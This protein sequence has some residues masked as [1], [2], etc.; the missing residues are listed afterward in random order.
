MI[1][2]NPPPPRP[3]RNG[4]CPVSAQFCDLRELIGSAGGGK[5]MQHAASGGSEG[6]SASSAGPALLHANDSE[7][8]P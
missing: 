6:M 3:A 5:R 2:N 8:L 4:A 1:I 7:G